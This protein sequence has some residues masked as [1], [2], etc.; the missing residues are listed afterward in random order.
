MPTRHETP[1]VRKEMRQWFEKCSMYVDGKFPLG[2]PQ[3]EESGY[4]RLREEGI[5][6]HGETEVLER[7]VR[8]KSAKEENSL[9]LEDIEFALDKLYERHSKNTCEYDENDV[10]VVYAMD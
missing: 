4:R 8:G 3:N 6:I 2:S 7:S 10:A 9:N 1:R 5:R